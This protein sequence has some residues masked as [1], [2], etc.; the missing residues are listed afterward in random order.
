VNGVQIFV[1]LFALA[2]LAVSAAAVRCILKTPHMR[3]KP[4]WI[5]GCLAGFVGFSVGAAGH[6]PG[7]L[8]MEFGV[9]LPVL[10]LRWSA[11][12]GRV[13]IKALFP[14]IALVAL[15]RLR[16]RAEAGGDTDRLP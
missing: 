2:S 16:D 13:H 6:P 5:I 3:H 11:G 14:L 12:D 7:D 1:S 8:I 9:Q 10:M 4:G 15:I